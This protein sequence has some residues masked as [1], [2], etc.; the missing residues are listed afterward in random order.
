MDVPLGK[1]FTELQRL[2]Y[3]GFL[4]GRRDTGDPLA[5]TRSPNCPQCEGRSA[6]CHREKVGAV[7]EKRKGK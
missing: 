4:S 1:L 7:M 5:G 6:P 2:N 3:K